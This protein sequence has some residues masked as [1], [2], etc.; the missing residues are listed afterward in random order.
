[1]DNVLVLARLARVFTNAQRMFEN[2]CSVFG[3][4]FE[5]Q[6]SVWSER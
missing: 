3:L 1:M 5:L 6:M 4:Y 2:G